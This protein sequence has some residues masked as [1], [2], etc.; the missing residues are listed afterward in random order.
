MFF[1]R[2]TAMVFLLFGGVN[3]LM[4]WGLH[5]QWWRYPG[6]RRASW[7][8]PLVGVAFSGLWALTRTSG[9]ESLSPVIGII[10][11][12]LFVTTLMLTAALPFSGLALTLERVI[13]RLWRKDRKGEQRE[14]EMVPAGSVSGSD[15]SVTS[16]PEERVDL[17]RRSLV[18]AG[19]T[20]LPM[21]AV[22]SSAGGVVGATRGYTYTPVELRYPDLHPDLDGLKILHISD[23]H[24]GYYIT[25]DDLEELLIGAE[26]HR[27]DLVTVTGDLSDDMTVYHDALRMIDGLKP[28]HGTYA[29]LGNHE[30]YRGIR[31]VMAA[32]ERGPVPLL[33]ESGTTVKVGR[34]EIWVGG[35]DDPV[36]GERREGIGDNDVFLAKSVA[37]A[38][39]GAPSEAF[40]MM[41]THRPEGFDPAAAAG[42]DLT[43]A[44]HTH[45]GG[46]MGWNGRSFV[47]TFF[48]IGKYMW[49]LYEKNDG[50]S[51]LYTSAGAGHWL[52]FRL[53]VPREVPVYTL[54][55]GRIVSR[56]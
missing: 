37:E 54:R 22:G 33:L 30:Y 38:L 25:L 3:V 27:P 5:R 34:G 26:A 20:I 8:V 49:G 10:L 39:D 36:G 19:A 47:E 13:R 11:S 40:H 43:L 56:G 1:A 32:F 42:L 23:L 45:A 41:L 4:L 52:P 29:S 44:G 7:I 46:Q 51:K 6:V 55:R 15:L 50:A 12:F 48:G 31:E 35:A 14:G 17:R 16:G 53:G 2:V 24:L 18:T 9:L 28:R 21:I